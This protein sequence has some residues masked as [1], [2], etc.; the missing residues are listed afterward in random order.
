VLHHGAA[1][2]R[3]STAITSATGSKVPTAN[4]KMLNAASLLM[5]NLIAAQLKLLGV[6]FYARG[7]TLFPARIAARLF[8]APWAL[9]RLASRRP[10]QLPVIAS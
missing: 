2:Y 10:P 9:R 8:V 1:S 7:R 6:E 4:A 5:I 3:M